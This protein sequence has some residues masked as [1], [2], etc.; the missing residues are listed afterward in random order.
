L[1]VTNL[2]ASLNITFVGA[3]NFTGEGDEFENVSDNLLDSIVVAGDDV[4]KTVPL[5]EVDDG[6]G[7]LVV[8]SDN[9]SYTDRVLGGIEGGMDLR[10]RMVT[11]LQDMTRFDL[12]Y[13]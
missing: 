8:M 10:V 4:S 12:F 11:D 6:D 3:I 2:T 1:T 9:E 13:D 5:R 7:I